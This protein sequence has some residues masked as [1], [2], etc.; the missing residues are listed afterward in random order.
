MKKIVI[1]LCLIISLVTMFASCKNVGDSADT[2]GKAV[3]YSGEL[4]VN[5]EALKQFEK[6]ILN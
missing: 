2:N 1:F 6:K 5:T 3:E 4:A